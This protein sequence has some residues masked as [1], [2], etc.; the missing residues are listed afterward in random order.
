MLI[1]FWQKNKKILEF[2]AVFGLLSSMFLI[3]FFASRGGFGISGDSGIVDE[4]AHIPAGYSYVKYNDFRLNP[5][6]PPLAKALAGLSLVLNKNIIGPIG[7]WSWEGINQWE[8]GWYMLYESGNNPAEVLSWARLPMIL[9]ML[10]LGVIL[11]FWSKKLFGRTVSLIVL[12][13]FAFYPDIIAHGKFVTTDVASALGYIIAVY[14]F[15]LSLTNKTQKSYI[16]AG[17]LF[18][19]AQLLKFSAIVL[20]GVFVILLVIR[21]ITELSS[22]KDFWPKLWVNFKSFSF[23]C[24]YSIVF[25]WIVY[26]PFTWNTPSAI[27][28]QVIEINLPSN[29]SR[30]MFVKDILHLLESNPITRA[31][32]HYFLGIY[33]VLGRVEGGNNTFA[34]G[35]LSH[36]SISWFFPF[37]WAVKTPLTIIIL[38]LSSLFLVFGKV[39]KKSLNSK[40]KWLLWVLFTPIL[41]YWAITLKGSLNIGIRHLMP[42]IPF[43]LLLIGWFAQK[44]F[45][46]KRYLNLK[47]SAIIILVLFMAG[48]TIS[49]FPSYVGYFNELVPRDKRYQYLV[50]SSLDWGQ[51]LLRLR[52]FVDDQKIGKIKIDYFGGSVPGYYIKGVEDWHAEYGPTAG[53]LAISATYYQSSKLV[54]PE[55]G[56]WSYQWLDSYTPEKIIGGSIL[57]FRISEEDLLKNPPKSPYPV[58]KIYNVN[59]I[60]GRKVGL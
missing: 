22:K 20:F 18:G 45:Q 51:D 47:W 50:D 26:L 15:D 9:L 54:G 34:L 25:V 16:I 27:E 14:G 49:Y 13:L 55:E 7:D 33:M 6:H 48:S 24:L 1:N 57:V 56:K 19:L 4:I 12:S 53:W 41:L 23:V 3:T 35:Q 28:H 59:S 32:G 5:E 11:Y 44:L 21:T 60:S 8:S 39:L 52:D 58:T 37:A 42:T 38:S 10:V 36:K 46:G 29:E 30:T 43:V 40:E 2:V 31:L 17:I